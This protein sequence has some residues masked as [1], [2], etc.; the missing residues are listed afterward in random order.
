VRLSAKS[1]DWWAGET[2]LL[3]G[4]TGF[5]GRALLDYF[6]EVYENK[7]NDFRVIV[8]SRDPE[9]FKKKYPIYSSFKWLSFEPGNVTDLQSMRSNTPIDSV[10]HAAGESSLGPT[11]APFDRFYQV[12]NG[13]RNIL[14]V[15]VKRGAS[16]FLYVSSGAVYGSTGKN[17]GPLAEDAP[18]SLDTSNSECA[19]GISKLA[20]EHQA[21]LF[22]NKYSLE[23][24]IARCFSFSGKDLPLNVHFALGNFIR[25]I[26]TKGVIDVNGHGLETRAYMDQRDLAAWL[27]KL[28]AEGENRGIYNVGSDEIVTIKELA[29]RIRDLVSREAKVHVKG[30]LAPRQ[31]RNNY[32]P[33]ISKA[34]AFGLTLNFGLNDSI[35]E[36]VRHFDN[37]IDFKKI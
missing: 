19:Y 23:V 17:I 9:N 3:T 5:F 32:V 20:S 7:S 12:L 16:R 18:I 13:T 2:L 26:K 37:N 31:G 35:R 11:L 14:E 8:L 25:D 4:G 27:V 34:R 1:S 30:V 22:S 29:F 28:L 24:I 10:I 36:M 6:Q 15:S 33:D 21:V